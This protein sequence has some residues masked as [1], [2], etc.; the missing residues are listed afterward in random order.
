[1]LKGFLG[2]VGGGGGGGGGGGFP[3]NPPN[4]S[5]LWPLETIPLVFAT[6]IAISGLCLPA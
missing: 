2:G 3:R 4:S 1:M 5:D 6:A